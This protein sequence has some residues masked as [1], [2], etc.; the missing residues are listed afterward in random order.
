MM[1]V[2]YGH[3]PWVFGGGWGPGG[4]SESRMLRALQG[5][6]LQ[7]RVGELCPPQQL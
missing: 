2:L 3:F 5:W 6:G 7:A 4:E 1:A